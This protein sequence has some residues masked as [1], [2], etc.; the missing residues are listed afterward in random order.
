MKPDE[1]MRAILL[2][3]DNFDLGCGP[4]PPRVWG[5]AETIWQFADRPLCPDSLAILQWT[6]TPDEVVLAGPGEIERVER[7]KRWLA[8]N[9]HVT[10]WR[11][12]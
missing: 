10:F 6:L 12:E 3:G 4:F 1:R 9:P 2:D 7:I 8:A 11:R 5:R